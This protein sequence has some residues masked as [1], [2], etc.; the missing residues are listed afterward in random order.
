MSELRNST[1][2]MRGNPLT[3]VG[4]EIKVGDTA[5]DF[6]V[7][8]SLTEKLTLGDLTNK[9]KIFNVVLS[10]DTPVC[11]KQTRKFNEEAASL[12]DDVEI[13]TF[14]V[15][16]PFA[17]SRYCGAAG[18]DKIKAV[19]DYKELSFG[20]A[21][22]VLIDEFKLL[23]RAIFVID[24]DNVVKYV[25]YVKEVTEEPNYDSA[26]EAAKNLIWDFWMLKYGHRWCNIKI[27]KKGKKDR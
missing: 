24:K 6:T 26:L 23:S 4:P 14:S 8:K 22:G 25:E 5:P 19:S 7:Q 17:L 15:D 13:V 10:I 1:V 21:Y 16:L 2:K 20:N 12:G 11:D 18:I 3:L 27:T 9:V